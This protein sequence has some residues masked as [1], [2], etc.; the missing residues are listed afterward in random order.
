MFFTLITFI[1]AFLSQKNCFLKKRYVVPWEKIGNTCLKKAVSSKLKKGQYI[2]KRNGQIVVE[3]WKDKR[4]VLMLTTC[5]SE[6]IVFCNKRTRQEVKKKPESIVAYNKYMCGMDRMEQLVSYYSPLQKTLKWYRK[7]VLQPL[8]MA[9]TNA[10]LLY[11]K[12]GGL[13][14]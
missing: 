2:A 4:D 12:V 3:K 13:Q 10:F 1:L 5:Y 9:M 7:V 14:K 6:R 11:K 8:D